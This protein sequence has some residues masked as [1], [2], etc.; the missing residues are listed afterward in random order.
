[1]KRSSTILARR[2]R[3]VLAAAIALCFAASGTALA[4][5]VCDLATAGE[6]GN[7]QAN[8]EDAMACGPGA[9]AQGD[10]STAYGRASQALGLSSI[11]VGSYAYG[12]GDHSI[13]IGG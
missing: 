11:A 7:A 5:D 9:N 1:M 13:A 8:G 3:Q 2:Q 4:G 10:F 12:Q 6:N